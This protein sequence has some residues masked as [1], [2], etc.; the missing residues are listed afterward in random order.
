MKKLSLLFT[1]LLSI[2]AFSQTKNALQKFD[3]SDMETSVLTQK[4]VLV[5][6]TD[7]NKK[8]INTYSFY[9][10]YKAIQHGDLQK[11][12]PP[13]E[14]LK[15]QSRESYFTKVIPLAILHSDFESISDEALQNN[16]VTRDSEGYL[17]RTSQAPIFEQN[18]LTLA[19]SLRT[20][21]KGLQTTFKLSAS[22]I[23][24]TT[25]HDFKDIAIDFNDGLGFTSVSINKNIPITYTSAG[26]KVL[27]FKLILD[28]EEVIMRQSTIKV[29]PSNSDI[30]ESTNRVITTFNSSITPDLSAYG[31]AVSYPA[32]GEYEIYLSADGILDKPIFLVDGFDPGDGRDISGIYD[33]LGFTD[34][35]N[36]SNLGDL[37]RDADFDI[38]ILNFPIYTRSQDN[39]IIDGG[40]DFIERNA[41]LLVDLINMINAEKVGTAENVVIG[42]SMGG[43]ISRYAL[44]YMENQNMNHDTRLW[45]SFDSPHLGANVPI[46]FQHQF[47]FLAFGLNDF[48]VLGNQNV[49]ELQ[50]IIDGMLRSPAA[51]QMLTDQF[52]PHITNS[53]G[54]TFNSSLALPRAHPY[55]ATFDSKIKNLTNT[56]FPELI[57]NVSIINGSGINS[58]YPNNTAAAH[59]LNPG[60][61]ILN[62]N[63]SVTTGAT[64]KIQTYFTPYAGTQIQ[65]SKVHLDFAWW[66]PLANDRINNADSRAFPYSDGID[67]ASGGLF[68]LLKLTEDLD[69]EGLVGEF[70]AALSTDFFNFIPS[71]SAM[72]FE[73]TNNQTNWFHSL[74]GMTTTMTPFDAW[75]MPTVNEPHVT[76]TPGNVDFALY[77]ILQVETLS[78]ETKVFQNLKLKQNPITDGFTLVSTKEYKDATI[79]IVDITG[80]V[81]YRHK[82][83]INQSTTLPLNLASGMYILNVDTHADVNLRTKL[84]IK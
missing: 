81:V 64:M 46:G 11:R 73:T 71:V 13:L 21:H 80:K 24:N 59:P 28:N 84:L 68:D 51:R 47:N 23:F 58:R 79:S 14:N 77:E 42:P 63:I 54:V 36:T 38:V 70:L 17:L 15:E 40:V 69:T 26:K 66:F 48:W 61:R 18:H 20:N 35:G 57:R 82:T 33:L 75:Y 27:T 5:D 50:P 43:L 56:G 19:S 3:T 30:F 6:I 29:T 10:A 65:N 74:S 52:E 4:S 1:L 12:L 62:A 44:N 8:I 55:K 7:Y 53:D 22:H 9:Q 25:N 67:A 34:G 31:E 32:T 41:M 37:V 60:N 83:N 78:T 39:A 16:S 45:I 49:E 2:G 72:A 76:L